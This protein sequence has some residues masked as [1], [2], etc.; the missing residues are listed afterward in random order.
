MTAIIHVGMKS[1]RMAEISESPVPNVSWPVTGETAAATGSAL[2][3]S[4]VVA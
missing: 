2:I 4:D 1:S 3:H